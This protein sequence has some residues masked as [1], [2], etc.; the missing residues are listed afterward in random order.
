MTDI[1]LPES[2]AHDLPAIDVRLILLAVHL[3]GGHPSASFRRRGLRFGTRQD[4]GATS[5]T[6]PL[7]RP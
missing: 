2:F 5:T 4:V 6:R 1:Y 3:T 7:W